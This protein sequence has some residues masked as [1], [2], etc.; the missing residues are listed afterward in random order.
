MP[1]PGAQ[2]DQVGL[3]LGDHRQHVEQQPPDRVVRVVHRAAHAE[4]DL[5]HR[6]LLGDGAG[7]RQG[8]G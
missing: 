6:Q 8:A 3:E 1:S 2:P 4:P 7:V 5:P